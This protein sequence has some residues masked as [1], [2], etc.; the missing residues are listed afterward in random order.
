[1]QTISATKSNGIINSSTKIIFIIVGSF[2][3]NLLFWEEKIAINAALFFLFTVAGI[4]Y[5]YPGAFAHKKVRWLF[6]AS[7]ISLSMVVF[8]NTLLSKISFAVS[9]LLLASYSQYLHNSMLYAGASILQ[10]FFFFVPVF[11][12]ATCKVFVFG[13]RKFGM[14][15]KLRLAIIPLIIA[16]IFLMVYLL[17]NKVFA[18]VL[19]RA[20]AKLERVFDYITHWVEPER[21]VFLLLGLFISG[22]LLVRYIKAPL[23]KRELEKSD[24]LKRIH[25]ATARQSLKADIIQFFL[26]KSATGSSALKNEYKVGL[27]CFVLLNALLLMVNATDILY[28]WFGFNYRPNMDWAKFVH[29]GAGLLV[30]SILLAMLVVLYFFRGN[31]NFFTKSKPLRLL[32]YLW[33]AQNAVLAISV[34]VRNANYIQHMGLAYKRVGLYVYVLLVFIGLATIVIKIMKKRTAYYLWRVNALAAFVLLVLSA[35]I[36]WDVAIARYNISKKDTIVSDI[37]F[38]IRMNDHVLPLLQQNKDWICRASTALE[39]DIFYDARSA[40]TKCEMIDVRIQAFI[41]NEKNYTWLS[42]NRADANTTGQ[43]QPTNR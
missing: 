13:K 14:G 24:D 22:G 4:I 5:F 34:C 43:L 11:I 29:E 30:L 21:L 23:E 7:I 41:E 10:S 1:M 40:T 17:A 26:G 36:D 39:D 18:D 12:Q 8:H 28:V 20:A 15:K 42:W 2:L 31:L 16:G 19:Q 9:L 3:F 27:L 38:L 32:A 33:I 37:S 6:V 35:C 25:R